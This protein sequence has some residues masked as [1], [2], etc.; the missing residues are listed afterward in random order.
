MK[1]E[2][3]HPKEIKKANRFFTGAIPLL[4][5]LFYEFSIIT[6]N[7]DTFIMNWWILLPFLLLILWGKYT[8]A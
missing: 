2:W 1:I 5:W 4:V 3:N 7:K 8:E 6:E